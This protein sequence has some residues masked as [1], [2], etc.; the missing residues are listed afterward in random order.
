M[1]LATKYRPTTL[2]D[3]IGQDITKQI[4][5]RQIERHQYSNCYLF[6]GPSGLGKTTLCRILA[7]SINSNPSS[8]FEIDAASNNGVDNVREI[9]EVAKERSLDG[10]YKIFILDEAHLITAAGFAA[11]LKCIEETPKYTIFMFCT[12]DPQKVPEAIRNRCMR[13]NLTRVP[14]EAIKSRLRY[15]SEQETIL[16]E[17]DALDY[18]A[19]VSNGS[20]REAIRNLEYAS[21]LQSGTTLTMQDV[22]NLLYSY[23]YA[24]MFKLV[25]SIID[26]CE[27]DIILTLE[28]MYARGTDMISF[29]TGFTNFVLELDKFCCF[30]DITLTHLPSDLLEDVKYAC[31]V[32]ETPEQSAKYY[33]RL[34][35]GLLD[36]RFKLKGESNVL[37]PLEALLLQLAR[38]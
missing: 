3:V 37:Y 26:K 2:Q 25:N 36:I 14:I 5:N 10:G 30:R 22:M 17:D 31:G 4:L 23:S 34:L 35:D 21:Q 20:V 27:S 6:S 32:C 18:L 15:I 33:N 1:S 13:F 7:R 29:L 12:T 9:V 8:L 38:S 19:R 11:F 28:Q 16:I 24:D